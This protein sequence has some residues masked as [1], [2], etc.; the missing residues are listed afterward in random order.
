MS[1]T[2][3][4]FCC[5]FISF[6]NA[7]LL[8]SFETQVGQFKNQNAQIN[9][10]VLFGT[11][12]N[13]L[14]IFLTSKGFSYQLTR[15]VRSGQEFS[16][17]N[18]TKIDSI[19]YEFNRVDIN[20]VGHN[21]NFQ[22]ETHEKA[23]T[24]NY[25][26][27]G[28][29]KALAKKFRRVVYKNVYNHIDFEFTDVD[30]VFKYNII[31]HPGG[32]LSNI[33]LD[34]TTDFDISIAHKEITIQTQIMQIVDHI[35][36][37]YI[38]NN[39][40]KS[41]DIVFN[42][43]NN[44]IGYRL[45]G[46]SIGS[47]DT[48]IIDPMPHLFFGTY[49]GGSG[50][51]YGN[52]ITVDEAGNTYITG[53]S[54]SLNNIATSGAFQGV[55]NAVFDVFVAKFT[56]D[57]NRVWGTYLG[58]ASYDRAYGIDYNNGHLYIVG[59]TYSPNMATPGAY[60]QFSVD[61]DDA[62]IT[63]FDTTGNRMWYTYYGGDLHDF[64]SAVVTDSDENIYLTGH[65]LSSF[66]ITTAGAHLEFHSGTAGA[67]L[68]KF[69]SN[70]NLLW[71][72]F[73]GNS[74]EEGWGIALDNDENPL[75]S[76]FTS[77]TSGIATAGSHQTT[78]G[79]G[80][81]AFL[82]KFNQN[83]VRIWGTY[84]G[85]A[86]QD[87]GYEI[88]C[89]SENN[90][91]FVGS[92]NSSNGI[93]F[94][95]GYQSVPTS[96]DDG[97]VAKF[98]PNGTILWGTYVGGNEADYLYGVKNYV[99]DGVLI[100]GLTQSTENIA[101]AGAYQ[102]FLS[103]QYDA[104]VQKLSPNGEMEWGSYYG[105]T[106]S[107]EAR[108]IAINSTNAHF[109]IVGFTMS[110]SGVSSPGAHQETF[111]GGFFDVFVAKFCAPIFPSLNYNFDDDICTDE[112]AVL[113]VDSPY[114]YNLLEWN[115]GNMSSTVD[116]NALP[117]GSYTFYV[118]SLDTNNCPGYSD[119]IQFQKF[120]STPLTIQ[121]NQLV[122]CQ[123]DDLILWSE[124]IFDSYLW[125]TNS[126]DTLLQVLA[127]N[128]G[129]H[130]YNLQATNS[131]GCVSNENVEVTVHQNPAPSV[132]VLGS[133]NFCL[134]ETVEIGL[135]GTYNFYQWHNGLNTPAIILDEE[136]TVWVYV[137]NEFGCGATTQPMVI[138][139]DVLTPGVVVLSSPP[140]CADSAVVF[141][142]NNVYDSYVWMNGATTPTISIN[143]GVNTHYIYVNVSN[144]CGGTAQ[145]DSLE[146]IINPT[147]QA[148]IN[149]TGSAQLCVGETFSFSLDG[150]FE[151]VVWQ[152]EIVSTSFDYSPL[153]SGEY[154]VVVETID[155]KGC[156]SY[157]TLIVEFVDCI[158][159]Y[160]ING[161]ENEWSV[162]PNPSNDKIQIFTTD[163]YPINLVILTS[164]GKTVKSFSASTGDVIDVSNL[165][166][167]IYAIVP[168]QNLDRYSP[169]K[170]VIY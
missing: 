89:D 10:E 147:T 97:F 56:P 35:P 81:D 111:S 18:N 46:K 162:F 91:Y 128:S 2:I 170:L 124:N 79:G 141:G 165:A 108:G 114:L 66:N 80:M 92:T 149:M 98:S 130:N 29:E 52:E 99:N 1:F 16:C 7:T 22:V 139:S 70:G 19:F 135:L 126:S 115:T 166:K 167:G 28:E 93:F 159:N 54:Q 6:L 78:F 72:T 58:G 158:L 14:A 77:S 8:F 15:P 113:G 25:Y 73:Y 142:V 48:L 156:P 157:D 59:S 9:K 42:Q 95:S 36:E 131:F 168:T 21:N 47:S 153:T 133:A 82:A 144:L 38:L 40:R 137:E 76:G 101:T 143:L 34:Y 132:N 5:F 102:E 152:N 12:S 62:F 32:D 103:G 63:K 125:S 140:F 11:Q 30:G 37:S 104:F 116:L 110:N 67:F 65:S 83:G 43:K 121:Q 55:F 118:N 160:P 60:Q 112:D 75:F 88:D 39:A 17:L 155:L 145:S 163:E 27:F 87:F 154:V 150:N 53:H 13:G 49:V 50:D 119:T 100:T 148:T 45:T 151:S 146:I 86:N 84:F 61:N 3:S 120:E 105:G 64:A 129:L 117:V 169:I 20:F 90:I 122:Y 134:G 71:G 33:V 74:F 127:I 69:S 51:E 107:D 161:I 106:L 24:L 164:E 23:S 31:V 85:G 123:G 109:T 4:R 41:V 44:G 57:G 94:N 26:Y 138:D 136:D 96:I 68:A